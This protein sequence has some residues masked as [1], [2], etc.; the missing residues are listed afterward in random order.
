M[1]QP[2]EV[3]LSGVRPAIGRHV[4]PAD[5]KLDARLTFQALTV[6]SRFA[7]KLRVPRGMTMP[8]QVLPGRFYLLTRRTADRQ[9]LLRPDAEL[10]NTFLYCL[11]LT[12]QRHGIQVIG[13]VVLSDHYHAIVYDPHGTINAFSTDF[14]ALVARTVNKLRGRHG[15]F[16]DARAP[17]VVDLLTLGTVVEKLVYVMANPVRHDLVEAATHWP[18]LS[19]FSAMKENR[20]LA[21]TRPTHFFKA[22]GRLPKKLS[23]HLVIPSELGDRAAFV[24]GVVEA[25]REVEVCRAAQRRRDK[26]PVVG[27]RRVIETPWASRASTPSPS[28]VLNPRFAS[29]DD[30]AR[31]AAIKQ[32]RLFILEYRHARE[33]WLSGLDAVFP[34]GTYWLQ[35]FMNVP[36]EVA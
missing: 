9:F 20:A 34:A 10:N 33:L 5:K 15:H 7:R 25:V 27:R 11:A 29:R 4:R 26:R 18:G 1:R 28:G 23:L 8:R 21:A 35:R 14:H 19:S 22:R 2:P 3:F 12:S 30:E 32:H 6:R 36:T 31:K 16:W 24:A 17:S 13:F